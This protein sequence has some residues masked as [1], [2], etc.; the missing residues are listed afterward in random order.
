MWT[1]PLALIGRN[2]LGLIRYASGLSELSVQTAYWTFVAPF[3]GLGLK[4]RSAVHQAVLVGY[5]AVPIVSVISFFIGM[6]LA[7]QGAYQL[8][9]L[10]ATYFVAAL[11]GV[12]MTRELGP[13]I[14]AVVVAGRSGSAFAAEIGTMKVSEEIDALEVMGLNS[15][16]YLVVPKYLAMLVMMPCLTLLSDAAGILGGAAFGAAQLDQSFILYAAAT[17]EALVMKDISTGLV[18]SIVFGA[19]IT[20]VGC[21]EG[22]AVRGGAEGVGKATTSSV[23]ISIFTVIVADLLFTALFYYTN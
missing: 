1:A 13:L 20:T 19:V 17:S 5:S 6:V 15:V 16:K 7:F 18:K 4:G 10:G 2:T 12:S 22:F 14:T 9:K 21:Y 23:V 8:E 3:K 11:V